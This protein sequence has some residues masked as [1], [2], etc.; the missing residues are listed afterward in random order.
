MGFL[1]V[2]G[3]IFV[4]LINFAIFFVLLRA[5]FLGPVG[6]AVAARRDYINSLTNDYDRYQGEAATLRTQAQAI[7]AQARRES[8]AYLAKARAEATDEAG[9]IAARYAEQVQREIEQANRTVD[10]ELAA[11]RAHEGQRAGE[12]AEL[13]LS[14]TLAEAS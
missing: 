11:A 2:D 3:T 5:I 14:R 4:Q 9:R 7:R 1:S 10:A 8:E 13:M 6:K 12:L